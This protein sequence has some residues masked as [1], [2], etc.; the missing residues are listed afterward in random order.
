MINQLIQ[1]LD[2]LHTN[3]ERKEYLLSIRRNPN[4][5]RHDFRRIACNVLLDSNFIDN[6]YKTD[7]VDFIKKQ[8]KKLGGF[9]TKFSKKI[10]K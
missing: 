10:K 8:L 6:Y 9:F 4:I 7:F 5:G 2:G 3:K 1:E